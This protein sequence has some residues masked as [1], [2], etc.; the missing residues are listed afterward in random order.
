[1]S[2]VLLLASA[3]LQDAAAAESRVLSLDNALASAF[4]NNPELAAARWEIDIA[5][6]AASRPG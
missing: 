6:G 4:A 5:Q 3:A 2:G 1:M